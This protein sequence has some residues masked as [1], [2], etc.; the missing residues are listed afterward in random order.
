MSRPITTEV[1]PQRLTEHRAAQ[2][3]SR[4]ALGTAE[5]ERIEI[6]KLRNKSAVYRLIGVGPGGGSVIA[7]RSRS[8]TVSIEGTIYRD[9][10]PDA[11]PQALRYYG[12]A[13]EPDGEFCWL[14]IESADGEDYE[15]RNPRHRALAGRWLGEIHRAAGR[16]DLA[17]RLP[18]REPDDYLERVR[19]CRSTFLLHLGNPELRGDDL[20]TLREMVSYCDELES[21]WDELESWC[22]HATRTLVHGDFA[23]KNV[24]VRSG[25]AGPAFLVF[26]WEC[27]G[28]GVPA[29]DLAQ[30]LGRTV[31]PDLAAY[32]TAL[33]SS[34]AARTLLAAMRIARC[35]DFFRLIDD[36]QWANSSL[37]FG[38]Y[39][40][41]IKPMSYLQSYKGRLAALLR[42]AGWKA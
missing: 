25:S 24:R 3:W 23:A 36:I 5:P 12:T 11:Q 42:A 32:C 7:K 18:R 37:G 15:I 35:G 17:T 39:L 4:L 38:P 8:A 9:F 22:R 29:A 27:A 41:L 21:H 16:T 13:E 26:D 40:T 31:S 34:F 6:L 19:E 1:L 2:A 33:Q 10:L 20:L 28:W 14:F 30:F